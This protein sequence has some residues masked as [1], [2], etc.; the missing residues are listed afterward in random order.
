MK[1]L[2]QNFDIVEHKLHC[3]DGHGT[4][5][6]TM[7]HAVFGWTTDLEIHA[8]ENTIELLKVDALHCL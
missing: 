4:H 1:I 6:M 3:Q 7:F 2:K 5:S 8:N